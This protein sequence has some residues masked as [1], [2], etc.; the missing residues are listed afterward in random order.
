MGILDKAVPATD[1]TPQAE[2]YWIRGLL[3]GP[4]KSGKTTSAMSLP[5]KKLLIDT[6]LRA[7]S[8]AGRS[9]VKVLTFKE[10][11]PSSPRAWQNLMYLYQELWIA[12]SVTLKNK[13]K[14][15]F[16]Y[17]AIIYDGITSMAHYAMNDALLLDPKHG[18][19]GTPAQQHWMPQMK[20]LSD[21]IRPSLGLPCHVIFTCHLDIIEMPIKAGKNAPPESKSVVYL[22]K[23]T[24]KLRTEISSWFDE[25]Y[26]CTR[27]PGRDGTTDYFWKTSGDTDHIDWLGSSLNQTGKYWK[28]PVQVQVS[29]TKPW[30]FEMLLNKRF[31]KEVKDV[32]RASKTRETSN[33]N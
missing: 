7:S 32:E 9:D 22:P 1:L 21:L 18:L 33:G 12:A 25:A 15:P 11:T 6:D 27:Q 20:M 23:I 31:K 28:D 30:G 17:D 19:G 26:L 13:G 16:P 24:G 10:P 8:I 2:N 4:S 3:A 29:D 14:I 5:G